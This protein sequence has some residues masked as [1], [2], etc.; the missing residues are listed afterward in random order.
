M[1]PG[2]V[3]VEQRH[4]HERAGGAAGAVDGGDRREHALGG[5]AGEAVCERRRGHAEDA[6]GRRLAVDQDPHGVGVDVDLV[7]RGQ[8]PVPAADDGLEREVV[9]ERHRH[10]ARQATE[11]RTCEHAAALTVEVVAGAAASSVVTQ[12]SP[13][14]YLCPSRTYPAGFASGFVA[15]ASCLRSGGAMPCSR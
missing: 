5:A 14:G 12:G 1:E 8:L 11:H 10:G 3:V 2:A 9:E 13:C 6:R 15:L 4:P 7:R